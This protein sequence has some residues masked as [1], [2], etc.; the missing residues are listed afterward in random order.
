[1]DDVEKGQYSGGVGLENLRRRLNLLYPGKHQL[2]ITD[3]ISTFTA[4]L[5]I[6]LA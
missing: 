5:K 4:V 1:V 6:E 3:G 2:V